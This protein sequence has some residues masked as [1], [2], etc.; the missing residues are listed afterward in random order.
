MSADEPG[1]LSG[2]ILPEASQEGVVA[3]TP[4]PEHVSRVLTVA[5]PVSDQERALTFYGGTLG[6]EL[7]RDGSFG[8][9]SARS[10]S[11][12]RAPK[13]RWRCRRRIPESSA[14]SRPAS[15]W[16]RLTPRASTVRSARLE[17]TWTRYWIPRRALNVLSARSRRE[18]ARDRERRLTSPRGLVRARE[19]RDGGS[20][21]D[22]LSMRMT[23]ARVMWQMCC[24]ERSRLRPGS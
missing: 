19:T 6:F 18:H 15:G 3:M 23:H 4:T 7:R 2:L 8:P 20:T 17:S 21:R 11:H 12:H 24:A 14:V 13:P 1:P 22:P 10:R 9:V 16:P 5:V